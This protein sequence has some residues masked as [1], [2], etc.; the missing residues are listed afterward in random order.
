MENRGQIT[1]RNISYIYLL[2]LAFVFGIGHGKSP[3]TLAWME[4][5]VKLETAKRRNLTLSIHYQLA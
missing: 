3:L 2:S 1:E 5:F 4:H